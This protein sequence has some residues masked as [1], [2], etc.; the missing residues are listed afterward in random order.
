MPLFIEELTKT[1][2]E[3]GLLREADDRYELTGPL[4][5]LAIPST[6]H[7]SL[8]A[9]LD[10]LAS[11]KDVA[12]IGAAIGREFSYAL[13]AAVAALPEKDL[14]AALAQLVGAELIFQRGVPPDATYQFKHALVQDAAYAS[15]VR[16]RRIA[17]HA[18]IVNELVARGSGG[19]E[20][21]PEV[22]GHHCAEAGMYEDAARHFLQAGEQSAARAALAEALML[23]DK[24]LDQM[25]RLPEGVQRDRQEIEGQCA[26]GAVLITLKGLAASEIGQ[27]YSKAGRLWDRL[28]RPPE[29][30]RVPWGQWMYHVNRSEVR[31]ALV[32][33]ESLVQFGRKHGDNNA[34]FLGNFCVGTTQL[35]KGELIS[36]RPKLQDAVRLF[37][38]TTH[39]QLILQTGFDPYTAAL[40]MLGL[41]SCWLGY[42]DQAIA[43]AKDAIE[44]A[45]QFDHSPTLGQ[46]LA[47]S[48]RVASMLNDEANL[49]SWVR[50]LRML[51]QEHGFPHWWSQVL[52]FE[53]QLELQRSNAG[54]AIMHLRQGHEA[55]RATGATLW[56]TL[57]TQ[58]L[59][60]GSLGARWKEA[61]EA[62][63]PFSRATSP[64]TGWAQNCIDDADKCFLGK[65][66]RPRKESFAVLSMLPN[67]VGKALGTARRHQP[68]STMARAGEE[69]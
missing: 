32:H 49:A 51:A 55:Y 2:L 19:E 43:H 40:F 66:A 10:R 22:L 4:P 21:R 3:S 46:A 57:T 28:G 54:A 25:A 8:L 5:P 59:L 60:S 14:Q 69:V 26:R 13:I 17:L 29:F 39:K 24:A 61:Q 6:L 34:L 11:V 27:A 41:D 9:R 33:A 36:A 37:Q 52:I 31:E 7:A 20:V 1:V 68:R 38:P 45:R 30:L 64:R 23:F 58:S 47:G 53:G 56:N 48:A 62:S 15:L 65:I 67:A 42:P 50:E 44:Q 63:C 12:Q 18:A 16:T 35:M